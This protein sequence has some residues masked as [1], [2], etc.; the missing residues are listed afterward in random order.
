ME[1]KKQKD[2]SSSSSFPSELFA[3]K[4]FQP[5]SSSG[6]FGSIFSPQSPKVLGRESLRSELN[7]KIAN[8][9][10]KIRNQDGI[11][12]GNEIENQNKANK[13]MSSKY[14]DQRVQPCHLCSSIMYGAQDI[15]SQP[16][17]TQNSGY[18]STYKNEALGDDSGTDSR[19][20]WWQGG[21][22][23]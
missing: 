9:S 18:T 10:W 20:N 6:I 4:E 11:Y 1:A 22:Y 3:S 19:G 5:S 23:Y 13:D 8:E 21:P 12:K 14:Q 15:Y 2:S 7:G 17:S 16:Q